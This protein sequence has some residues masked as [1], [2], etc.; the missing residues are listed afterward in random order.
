MMNRALIV[1]G[2]YLAASQLVRDDNYFGS[3]E[4]YDDG[5]DDDEDVDDD[6]SWWRPS[7]HFEIVAPGISKTNCVCVLNY[8]AHALCLV[9]CCC[10]AVMVECVDVS[11]QISC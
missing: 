2:R 10:C 11:G 9:R 4:D 6:Q 3:E 1:V 8:S 5:D 7:L